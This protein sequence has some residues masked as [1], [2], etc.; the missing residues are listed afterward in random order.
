MLFLIGFFIHP[1]NV[2]YQPKISGKVTDQFGNP[3][4]NATVNRIEQK[5]W[6]NEKFG[7]YEFKDFISQ[8]VTTDKN[9]GFTL[10]EKS[11]IEWIHN[12]PFTL[13]F[14]WC[15]TDFEI[16]KNGFESH[17]TKFDDYSKYNETHWAC[18][19]IEFKPKIVLKKL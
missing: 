11:R 14:V 4:A 19:E 5:S 3:I 2:V 9:G 18:D 1:K 10:N 17:R 6:K 8:T 7:Y 16:S 13:P 15:N 12:I